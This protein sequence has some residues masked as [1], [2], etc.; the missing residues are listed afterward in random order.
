MNETELIKRYREIISEIY[1]KGSYLKW[2][3]DPDN[4]KSELERLELERQDLI[5]KL[6]SCETKDITFSKTNIIKS[7]LVQLLNKFSR[8][9]YPHKF[10]R[11]QGM[12]IQSFIL[13]RIAED[14]CLA[15]LIMISLSFQ[16]TI[17]K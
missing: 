4:L 1:K 8:T 11:D 2:S 5:S 15:H 13:I 3:K 9:D 16:N 6:K 7:I 17:L 12:I 10:S 14:L